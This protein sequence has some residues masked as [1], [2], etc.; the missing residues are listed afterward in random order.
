MI[1]DIINP[2]DAVTLEADDVVV[3]QAA[4]LLLGEG[5]YALTNSEGEE[6]LPLCVF[7]GQFEKWA[8]EQNFNLV[9]ILK[10][11][12]AEVTTCLRSVMCCSISDRAAIVAAVG[13]DPEALAR[14]NDT[15]RSS[16]NDICGLAFSLAK[17]RIK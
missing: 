11:H 13:D 12:R 15:K 4:C 17:R 9:D 6:V 5:Q 7:G 3:A 10:N 8:K 1:Y 16:L 14:Y 2:S